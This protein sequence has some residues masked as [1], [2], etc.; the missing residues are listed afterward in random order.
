VLTMNP[1]TLVASQVHGWVDADEANDRVTE[2]ARGH[3]TELVHP[4]TRV[5]SQQGGD[6]HRCGVTSTLTLTLTLFLTGAGWFCYAR[7][8]CRSVCYST[9]HHHHHLRVRVRVSNC[10]VLSATP[11]ITTTTTA[12]ITTHTTLTLNRRGKA[13]KVMNWQRKRW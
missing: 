3:C 4:H 13:A 1:G 12:T 8:L 10:V 2:Q 6:S 5:L 7:Q 9:H 11:H